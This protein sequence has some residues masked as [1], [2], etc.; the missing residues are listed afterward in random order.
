MTERTY[1]YQGWVLMP[2]FKPKEVTLT[3]RYGYASQDYGDLTDSSK[4]YALSDIFPDKASAI[5]AGW[6]R[7]REQQ[8]KLDKVQGNIN[9]R[10]ANLKKAETT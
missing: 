2:S 4:L 9:K 1:P 3:S 10:S 5:A 8:V 6:E 7:L